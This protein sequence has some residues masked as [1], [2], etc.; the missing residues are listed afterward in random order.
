MALI[1]MVQIAFYTINLLL[2]SRQCIKK[3]IELQTVNVT[4]HLSYSLRAK[5]SL[6]SRSGDFLV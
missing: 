6:P 3:V 1:F 5:I 4:E 2:V